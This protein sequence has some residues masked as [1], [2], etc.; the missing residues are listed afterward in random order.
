LAD[1]SVFLMQKGVNT[2]I[3][4]IGTGID[5]TIRQ[6]AETVMD[7]VGFKGKIVFD[8]SKPD[9]TPRKLLDVSRMNQLG[10]QASTTLRKGI[11]QTYA[12]YCAKLN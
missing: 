1:A 3:Y 10:W 6:L 8:I 11:E 5:I 2:G 4:N 7:V 12:D 9:G